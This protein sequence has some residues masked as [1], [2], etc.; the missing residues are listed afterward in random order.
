MKPAPV[1]LIPT[2]AMATVPIDPMGSVPVDAMGPVPSDAR[3]TVPID[4]VGPVPTDTMGAVGSD[5]MGPVPTD[6]VGP[7]PSDAM[8]PWASDAMGPEPSDAMTVPDTPPYSYASHIGSPSGPTWL[9][10]MLTKQQAGQ[11]KQ[12]SP[13]MLGRP[14]GMPHMDSSVTHAATIAATQIQPSSH[15]GPYPAQVQQPLVS[16]LPEG[17]N[18]RA[19][20]ACVGDVP[21][22]AELR[23]GFPPRG[24][25]QAASL[26]PGSLPTTVPSAVDQ[27]RSPGHAI[28]AAATGVFAA[29]NR[30]EA[31]ESSAV[32]LGAVRPQPDAHQLQGRQQS[33]QQQSQQQQQQSQ[34]Q[35]QQQQQ[36]SSTDT[37][38]AQGCANLADSPRQPRWAS[39]LRRHQMENSAGGTHLLTEA[40]LRQAHPDASESAKPSRR[41]CRGEHA[42]QEAEAASSLHI[43]PKVLTAAHPSTVLRA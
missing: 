22:Q 26:R 20:A 31:I 28:A 36:P 7:L 18:L 1:G 3:G 32:S 8:G 11:G 13:S 41:G 40:E 15:M 6:A 33:Q 37:L 9:S 39:P 29:W 19:A 10:P 35:S 5:A 42:P 17:H 30:Q 16:Q 14:A 24:Q 27:G 21:S 23:P 12:Y 2:D 43:S 34:Q 25:G 4:L 38:A